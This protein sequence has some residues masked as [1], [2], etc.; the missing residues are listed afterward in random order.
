MGFSKHQSASDDDMDAR[1]SVMPAETF[2]SAGDVNL[3]PKQS[4]TAQPDP[5]TSNIISQGL[6]FTMIGYAILFS[7]LVF[8][9]FLNAVPELYIS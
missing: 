9:F 7:S 3:E 8:V 1:D 2:V 6:H 4:A 5:D